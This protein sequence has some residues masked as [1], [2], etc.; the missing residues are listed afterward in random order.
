MMVPLTKAPFYIFRHQVAYI[1]SIGGIWI[2]R[3]MEILDA[4]GKAVPGL[5]AAGTAACELYRET[6]TIDKPGSMNG[7]NIYSGRTAAKN[8]VAAIK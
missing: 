5:Y 7:H 8:A 2:N 4:S 3:K 6:Y 1:T